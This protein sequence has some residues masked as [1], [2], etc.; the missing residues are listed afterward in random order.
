V[1]KV[2][3]VDDSRSARFFLRSCIPAD[4]VEILEAEN[5]RDGVDR[6]FEVRPDLVFMDL[7]M[8]VMDGFDAV[9]AIRDRD[10]HA[11]IVV[12]TADV[13]RRTMERIE[14]AGVAY[15]LKKPPRKE[16]VREAL[17]AVLP[18]GLE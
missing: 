14:A 6:Y 1:K 2:L 17:N 15:V 16:S 5:G 12:L 18:G 10:P 3:I 7:T 8:P 11:T 4:H 13:Q 9:A